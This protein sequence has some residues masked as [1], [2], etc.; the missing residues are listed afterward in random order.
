MSVKVEWLC[1]RCAGKTGKK[2]EADPVVLRLCSE[3]K[4]QNWVRPFGHA[5]EAVQPTA[6]EVEEAAVFHGHKLKVMKEATKIRAEKVQEVEREAEKRVIAEDL[7]IVGD[8]IIESVLEEIP[9]P[10]EAEIED[11]D[12]D[13]E[14]VIAAREGKEAEIAALKAQLAE[15]ER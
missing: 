8:V 10:K 12:K 2:T 11:F 14:I 6:E 1:S 15:L 4:V 13:N 7:E 5:G 9:D 3:C